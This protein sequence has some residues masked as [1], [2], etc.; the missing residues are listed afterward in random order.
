MKLIHKTILFC[1][2]RKAVKV[3]L[4]AIISMFSV[5]ITYGQSI[6]AKVND[7]LKE[8]VKETAVKGTILVAENMTDWFKEPDSC[9]VVEK[10]APQ[11]KSKPVI[12]RCQAT[13]PVK[14][15]R[16]SKETKRI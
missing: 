15:L 14:H 5:P 12:I 11:R 13:V 16:A 7:Y 4:I 6:S 10:P 9:P 3:I 2:S 8:Q 1:D